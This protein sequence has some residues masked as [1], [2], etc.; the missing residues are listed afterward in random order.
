MAR[1][2]AAL[3][4]RDVASCGRGQEWTRSAG[5]GAATY[6][7]ADVAVVLEFAFL[8]VAALVTCFLATGSRSAPH[9]PLPSPVLGA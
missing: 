5:G 7:C 1:A 2:A 9:E 3:A 6:A 8:A 4:A